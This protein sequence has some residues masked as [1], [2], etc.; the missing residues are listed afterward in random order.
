M[1]QRAPSQIPFRHQH[2]SIHF[3][4]DSPDP[5]TLPGRLRVAYPCSHLPLAANLHRKPPAC[6]ILLPHLSLACRP[7]DRPSAAYLRLAPTDPLSHRPAPPPCHLARLT[8]PACA[9]PPPAGQPPPDHR[10]SP[11]GLPQVVPPHGLQVD[12]CAAV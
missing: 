6:P 5:L 3:E 9:S 2:P 10:R 1:G 4:P 12:P 11:R 8:H 7:P